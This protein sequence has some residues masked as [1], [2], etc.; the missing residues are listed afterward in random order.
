MEND[1]NPVPVGQQKREREHK[2][3][4]SRFLSFFD[5]RQT[6]KTIAIP[7]LSENKNTNENANGFLI[8]NPFPTKRRTKTRTKLES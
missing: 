1:R 4:A 8:A 2:V 5:R 3:S 7:F 6:R